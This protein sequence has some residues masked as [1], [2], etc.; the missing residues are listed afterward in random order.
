MTQDNNHSIFI[1][2]PI[3]AF[4][5][6]GMIDNVKKVIY[7][8]GDI[9][10]DA[11]NQ[12]QCDSIKSL[13]IKD[14]LLERFNKFKKNIIVDFFMELQPYYINKTTDKYRGNYISTMRSFFMKCFNFDTTKNKIYTHHPYYQML[15]YIT[16]I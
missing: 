9:H 4:R 12:T 6:E 2:G 11:N 14:Y 16:W 10:K 1:N 5:M 7:I 8:Y 15:G 13:E 3:N